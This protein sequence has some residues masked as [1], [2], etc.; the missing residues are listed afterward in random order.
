MKTSHSE[1]KKLISNQE[2]KAV[3]GEYLEYYVDAIKSLE[4]REKIKEALRMAPEYFWT[5]GNY[6]DRA[7]EDEQA[8]HGILRRVSK[9]CYF[10]KNLLR[11]WDLIGYED[12][13]M[14]AALLHE[15]RKYEVA[16]PSQH[17]PDTLEWL[18]AI[19]KI[20]PSADAYYSKKSGLTG[21]LQLVME[22]IKMHDG[23]R[24]SKEK[25][26]N[27]IDF[28]LKI[29]EVCAWLIHSCDFLA[30]RTKVSF[31]WE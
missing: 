14:A 1:E 24:W 2:K 21:Q 23:R 10:A 31:R 26:L 8:R 22:I 6:H 13:I 5:K 3:Y 18:S 11:A 17:G 27:P 25:I 7:P 16:D 9:G 29:S 28:E 12:E 4:I 20:E 15:C 30:S 19:W